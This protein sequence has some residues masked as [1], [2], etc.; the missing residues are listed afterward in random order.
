[1]DE[2]EEKKRGG[3]LDGQR[4]RAIAEERERESIIIK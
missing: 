1:M 4:E 2:I 3:K